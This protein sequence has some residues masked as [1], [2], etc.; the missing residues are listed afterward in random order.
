MSSQYAL[1]VDVGSTTTKVVLCDGQG[2][3]V[4]SGSVPTHIAR[5]QPG[6]AEIDFGRCWE[7]VVAACR[8]ALDSLADDSVVER[9][10]GIGL[11]SLAPSVA[12]LAQDGTPLH[13]GI[14]YEDR[15]SAPQVS[16][17]LARESQSTI[18]P[19]TGIRIESGSTTLSSMLWLIE[20]RPSLVSASEYFGS[21]TTYLA[22]RLTESFGTDWASAQLSG[23]FALD[24]PPRWLED[25]CR[26][27]GIPPEKLPPHMPSQAR[28]GG[29]SAQAAEE[30]GV[31][32]DTAV[33]M[34]GPDAQAAA[35][36]AGLFRP[37]AGLLSLGT[38]SVLTVCS[39]RCATD[40]R[41]Y[42]RRHVLPGRYLHVAPTL[43]GGTTLRWAASLL[44]VKAVE[45]L[46]AL[47]EASEPGAGGVLFLPYLQGERAPIWDREARGVFYGLQLS[48]GRAQMARAVIEGIAF[49]VRNVVMQME[50][51]LSDTISPL[52]VTGGGAF[53]V[54][55]QTLSDVLDRPLTAIESGDSAA[56]GAA[57]L[58]FIA[59][60]AR[61][62]DW[63][64]SRQ[65][66][67]QEI[68]VPERSV[69][70]MQDRRF[71]AFRTLYTA[72]SQNFEAPT[73]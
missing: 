3:I 44:G 31:P 57:L 32:A 38:T 18:V 6:W 5:P 17:V 42:T 33:A 37:Q 43:T 29:V 34:G 56:Q 35:V 9:T 69:R 63:L 27:L 58:A 70:S 39:E 13:A 7:G 73:E 64:E 66:R 45:E 14:I 36:G 59:A 2:T 49:A 48:T 71:E 30:L 19:R 21:L 10:I 53:P 15:R 54:V 61:D 67:V 62:L 28:I 20:E 4:A 12:P 25:W 24:D 55:V 16:R 40:P 65:P 52:Y 50:G 68:Y 51:H 41:F 23:L 60:G 47:A 1:G 22:H 46:V 26:Q 11:T 8:Q 72:L